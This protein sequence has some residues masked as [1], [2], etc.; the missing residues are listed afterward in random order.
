ML[1]LVICMEWVSV[2]ILIWFMLYWVIVLIVFKLIFLDVFK[3]MCGDILLCWVMVCVSFLGDILLSSMIF[4][5]RGNI[6]LSCFKL[7]IFILSGNC[8]LLVKFSV[9]FFLI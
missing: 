4:G 6:I 8:M 7:L 1:M 2:L 9:D 5:V 3:I